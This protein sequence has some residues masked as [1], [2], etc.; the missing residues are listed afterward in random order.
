M[1]EIEEEIDSAMAALGVNP[2]GWLKLP[3]AQA[4]EVCHAAQD[5]F[6]VGNPRSWWLALKQPADRHEFPKGD[7]CNAVHTLVPPSNERCWFIPETEE[8]ELPVYDILVADLPG[9]L[10]SCQFFEYYLVGK[11]L[12]WLVVEND[13]N[14]VLVVNANTS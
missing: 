12:D 8:A 2:G 14:E 9:V 3:P 13:H 1:N 7:G 5:R 11:N 4:R 6:V 10:G